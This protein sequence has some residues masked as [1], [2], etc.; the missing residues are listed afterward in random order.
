VLQTGP[1]RD[2]TRKKKSS[3]SHT[4]R[5]QSPPRC[6]K[7]FVTRC[8]LYLVFLFCI[9]KPISRVVVSIRTQDGASNEWTLVALLSLERIVT[10]SMRRALNGTPRA[11][12]TLALV[13]FVGFW[14]LV[15]ICI[16]VTFV[17]SQVPPRDCAKNQE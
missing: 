10:T 12:I 3:R 7:S 17:A 14:L 13:H 11:A 6:K 9:I 1:K 15:R 8:R 5:L 4:R 16:I 2:M